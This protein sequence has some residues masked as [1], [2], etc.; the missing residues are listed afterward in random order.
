MK[1]VSASGTD[2][3]CNGETGPTGPQ[4]IAGP[5]GATGVVTVLDFESDWAETPVTGAGTILANCKTTPYTAGQ[6]EVATIAMDATFLTS[7]ANTG[8]FFA[9]IVK[10]EN[11]VPYGYVNTFAAA[12]SLS[13]NAANVA[14]HRKVSLSPGVSY[15]FGLAVY[16]STG[17]VTNA[18]ASCHGLVTI[19]KQ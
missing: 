8:Q 14:L 10:F 5:Q 11:G 19:L 13:G 17:T 7:T 2:Y 4:G 1:Y 15:V 3:V 12:D 6:N 16:L 18:G 9:G